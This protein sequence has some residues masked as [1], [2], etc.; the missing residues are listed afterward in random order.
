MLAARE[1]RAA[2]QRE[3]LERHGVPLI[4][5][6]LN[7]AGAIK[8]TPLIRRAF[9]EGIRRVEGVLAA[10]RIPVLETQRLFRFTGCEALWAVRG[11]AERIKKRMILCEEADDLGR[12][13]DLD[14]IGS[15]GTHLS[16]GEERKC[17]ICG[18]PVRA[19]ARSR[20][21]SGEEVF[22]RSCG[23]M[24]AYFENRF[25]QRV[26]LRAEK[27]LLYEVCVTPKPGLVDRL[28]NG[29][30]RDM[31]LFSFLSS[32]AALR[33]Y[34]EQAARLG[35]QC[36]DGADEALFE[37][38]RYQ[39][40]MAE[41]TM[42][43]AA[44]GANTHKGAIFSLGLVCAAAGA[45]GENA[46]TDAILNRVSHLAQ[47]PLKEMKNR[48]GN[49]DRTAGES[50]YL[51]SGL[52]GVRGEAAQGFPAVRKIALP[53][54]EEALFDGRDLNDAGLQALLSLMAQVQDSNVIKRG[55]QEGLRFMQETARTLLEDGWD[56]Q[57]LCRADEAFTRR[58]L[59]PGG[60]ADLLAMAYFFHF[61]NEAKQDA[62]E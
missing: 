38:L 52:T 12:L 39:G 51:E 58:N 9:L 18:Q 53:A 31:D 16:R 36:R 50:Q 47:T 35:V 5:F 54:M 45:C 26:A 24:T 56:R 60:C 11:D 41:K 34:F 2:R 32:A 23:I 30:H 49:G 61:L 57:S 15:D 59:S 46:E 22:R 37:N 7:I 28:N 14:V 42:R 25:I 27:A 33:P 4:S 10:E 20:A 17:L 6:S 62:A 48:N 29:A 13:F 8:D 44:R 43:Q 3:M 40:M 55:G 19:C 1:E 21:H